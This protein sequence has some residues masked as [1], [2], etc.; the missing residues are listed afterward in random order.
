MK[1]FHKAGIP[2]G[3]IL[4]INIVHWQCYLEFSLSYIQPGQSN[5]VHI[6]NI[7]IGLIESILPLYTYYSHG[8]GAITSGAFIGIF[9]KAR[10]VN[11]PY[12]N[13]Q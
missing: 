11:I 5:T 13:V 7:S 3:Y 9:S 8:D 4:S 1:T 2:M 6:C 10:V 12:L